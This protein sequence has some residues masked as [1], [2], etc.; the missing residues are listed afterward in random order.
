[1]WGRK[2]VPGLLLLS[3]CV[4]SEAQ[5]ATSG[6]AMPATLTGGALYTHRLQSD[7]PGARPAAASFQ[8]VLSPSVK[9]GPHWFAYSSLHIRSTPFF[10]Y[11]AYEAKREIKAQVAQ[12]FV[13]YTRSRGTTSVLVKAG[14]LI[15]AFGSFPLRYDDIDN[16]LLDQP[17]SYT[18]YLKLRPDQL[19]C[20]VED[21][22]GSEYSRSVSYHC[23]G[24]ASSGD[25]LTPVT[26]YGLPGVEIDLSS[27]KAD[28][29]LQVTNSS[30]SSPQSL[31]SRS[32]H[33]QWTV[34]GGYTLVQGFRIG[35][36]A[37]R[38]P[39]LDRAVVPF[40]PAG[41]NVR[42]FPAAGAGSDI[43][44]ARGRW[45]VNAEWQWLRFTYP[46]FRTLPTASFGYAEVKAV[47]NARTYLALRVAHQRNSYVED[48]TKRSDETFT[49]NHQS[50]E[51]ALGFRPNRRQLLKIGYE[52]LRTAEISGTR[53]NV[54]GL[55]FVTSLPSLSKAWR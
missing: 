20:N 40:L 35:F 11:D 3:W 50:Y 19:P 13:A 21:L 39:F 1:M 30:P 7:D 53:D 54:L 41:K 16:P 22:T 26:L 38:G 44:W 27:H 47:L 15:S 28:A 33:A 42:D 46:N 12:A 2:A 52:W 25:G 45:A 14:Q 49:P 4:Q 51:L 10:A 8:A 31:L 37:F 36:S 24:S 6:F 34:G 55:Q 32:Q 5:E 43:Q 29:R 18:T 9:L 48:L 17:L 23:G